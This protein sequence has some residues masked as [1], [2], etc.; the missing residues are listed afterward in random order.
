MV[1]CFV[2]L[3]DSKKVQ[4]LNLAQVILCS[5]SMFTLHLHGLSSATLA[6]CYGPQTYKLG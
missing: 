3:P 5:V 6:S 2:L 4:G 1:W